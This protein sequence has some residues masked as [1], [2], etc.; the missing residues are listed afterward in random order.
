MENLKNQNS[1]NPID[2]FNSLNV[3]MKKVFFEELKD[4]G[5]ISPYESNKLMKNL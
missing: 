4:Q 1:T 2:F 5:F 3:G